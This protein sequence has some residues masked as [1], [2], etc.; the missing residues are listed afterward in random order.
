MNTTSS[1]TKQKNRRFWEKHRDTIYSR[2]GGA[3]MGEGIVFSYGHSILEELV[4]RVSYFQ[5]MMLNATGRL[6]E[7]PVADW[8]EAAFMCVSWPDARIWCNTIGAFGGT[9]QTSA[10]AATA[11]GMLAADSTMYGTLPLIE[12]V[13]FIKGAYKDLE[14]GVSPE[15]IVERQCARYRGKPNIVGYARPLARGDER[16]VA[17]ERITDQLGFEIGPHLRLAYDIQAI[18]SEKFNETM[19]INGYYSAFMSDQGYTADEIYRISVSC[20]NSGVTAA[21]INEKDKVPDSFLPLQCNDID[22]QGKPARRV[23]DDKK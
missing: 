22:Y 8:V 15:K 12:G 18:L 1:K 23:P 14:N 20:V 4:G 6:P 7:R 17:M 5:L 3:I 19:N 10:V 11:A 2:V 9:L 21:Y 13:G 16:L